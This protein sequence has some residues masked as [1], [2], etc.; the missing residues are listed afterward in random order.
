LYYSSWLVSVA[1]A[2]EMIVSLP[3]LPSQASSARGSRPS[4]RAR[5]L[6][7]WLGPGPPHHWTF[8]QL[9]TNPPELLPCPPQSQNCILRH[10]SKPIPD[11]DLH[12]SKQA[13]SLTMAIQ[14]AFPKLIHLS[15]PL[16]KGYLTATLF[17]YPAK[18]KWCVQLLTCTA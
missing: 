4:T 16:T 15:R 11:F 5:Y 7:D 14:Y 9:V 12:A 6:V 3:E 8:A 17:S 1:V 2:T 18:A 13:S 10:L